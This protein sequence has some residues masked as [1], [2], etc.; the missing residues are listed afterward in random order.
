LEETA[1][2]TIVLDPGHGG[3]KKVGG[4]SPNNATGPAGLKEK[5]ATLKV[6]LAAENALKGTELQVI[7]TRPED[8]NL[9]PAE[10]PSSRLC[11]P[12]NAS[13]SSSPHPL[14][15]VTI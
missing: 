3:T 2:V 14:I 12:R 13:Q 8:K 15:P 7:F 5:E 9:S 6:A 11:G 10:R 4:S 1:L